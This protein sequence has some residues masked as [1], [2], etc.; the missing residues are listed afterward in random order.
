MGLG[1]VSC[2]L[3][4]LRPLFRTMLLWKTPQR[5]NIEHAT[6]KPVNAHLKKLGVRT[7]DIELDILDHDAAEKASHHALDSKRQAFASEVSLEM[8]DGWTMKQATVPRDMV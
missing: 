2:S 7:T 3:A 8:R 5:T 6:D 4:T 1:I